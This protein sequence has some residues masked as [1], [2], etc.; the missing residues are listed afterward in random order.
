MYKTQS[1]T[2]ANKS[3][4]FVN[5]ANIWLP[6]SANCPGYT[7]NWSSVGAAVVQEV[8]QVDL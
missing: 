8:E 1:A 4:Y 3:V 6:S 5:T 2:N 7:H